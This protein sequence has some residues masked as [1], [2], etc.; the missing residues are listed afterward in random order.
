MSTVRFTGTTSRNIH[1]REFLGCA[2]IDPFG[3]IE[4][5]FELPEVAYQRVEQIVAEGVGE[6]TILFDNGQRIDWFVDREPARGMGFS[7]GEGI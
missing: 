3:H 1:K 2:G 4:R 6:G 7:G 5:V